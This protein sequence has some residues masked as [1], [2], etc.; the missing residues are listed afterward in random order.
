MI[1]IRRLNS[2]RKYAKWS[3]T[4]GSAADIS[5]A[6]TRASK[7][8]RRTRTCEWALLVN[9]TTA[10]WT[11][12]TAG[13]KQREKCTWRPIRAVA[14][15]QMSTLLSSFRLMRRCWIRRWVMTCRTSWLSRNWRARPQRW[16]GSRGWWRRL[17]ERAPVAATALLS[18]RGIGI[19]T[20]K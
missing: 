5:Q 19:T 14:S 15:S 13:E 6:V 2:S 11:Q 8:W 9:L 7:T 3:R 1:M 12:T 17:G 16:A 18:V 10:F 20:T 4:I